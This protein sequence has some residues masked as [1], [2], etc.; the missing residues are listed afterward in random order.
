[1]T[2]GANHVFLI[3]VSLLLYFFIT[4][5]FQATIAQFHIITVL[6]VLFMKWPIKIHQYG[7]DWEWIMTSVLL[8]PHIIL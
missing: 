1:M 2:V 5:V 8:G 6:S 7:R 3:T 4:E